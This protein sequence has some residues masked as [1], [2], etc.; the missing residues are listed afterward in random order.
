VPEPLAQRV[1]LDLERIR[2]GRR[3]PLAPERIDQAVAG[4]DFSR[5]EEQAREQPR[6]PPGAERDDTAV[7]DNL[8]RPENQELRLLPLRR[9][10]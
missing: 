1:H 2:G 3:R 9:S 4:D 6:R 7:V 5:V 8:Q 10:A